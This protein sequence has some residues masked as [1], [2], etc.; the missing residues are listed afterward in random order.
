M[1]HT[2]ILEQP[3]AY[4][5]PLVHMLVALGMVA[6]SGTLMGN[7]LRSELLNAGAHVALL[8]G[9]LCLS[10]FLGVSALL[11]TVAGL[12]SRSWI[13]GQV[14]AN[15]MVW[16]FSATF[17]RASMEKPSLTQDSLLGIFTVACT[18]PTHVF[19]VALPLLIWRYFGRF[20]ISSRPSKSSVRYSIE[21]ILIL[22]AFLAT[23]LSLFR[24]PARLVNILGGSYDILKIGIPQGFSVIAVSFFG[25]IIVAP[26]LMAII[27]VR[28]QRFAFQFIL[29]PFLIITGLAAVFAFRANAPANLKVALI[30]TSAGGFS[31]FVFGL[32][33]LRKVGYAPRFR[34][35][36][37]IPKT[38][39]SPTSMPPNP[40]FVGPRDP[41]RSRQSTANINGVWQPNSTG[42]GL[43][44]PTTHR[45]ATQRDPTETNSPSR[46]NRWAIAGFVGVAAIANAIAFSIERAHYA[47][48]ESMAKQIEQ[49]ANEGVLIGIEQGKDNVRFSNAN[50]THEIVAI[51][52]S[53]ASSVLY[54]DL[55][56][57]LNMDASSL[58]HLA[59]N[60]SICTSEDLPD[61]SSLPD[62]SKIDF[63]G[64]SVD[65][66]V[67]SNIVSTTGIGLYISLAET[68]ISL[69]GIKSLIR[70]A[71][72]KINYLD[73]GGLNLT[74][75]DLAAIDFKSITK[76]GLRDNP[77]SNASLKHLSQME[78]LDLSGTEI[79]GGGLTELTSVN[80]LTI[81]RTR[82]TD[83]DL[84][85]LASP[86][87]VFALSI[88]DTKITAAVTSI[89]TSLVRLRIGDGP[90]QPT[91][92]AQLE[93][94]ML[95]E[96][97]SLNATKFSGSLSG[98]PWTLQHIDLRRSDYPLIAAK[99]IAKNDYS[100]TFN[101]SDH[102]SDEEFPSKNDVDFFISQLDYSGSSRVAEMVSSRLETGR[103]GS[104]LTCRSTDISGRLLTRAIESRLVKFAIPKFPIPGE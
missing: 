35:R 14:I 93:G 59:I 47:P 82:V 30:F 11:I 101:F 7:L 89:L 78:W 92:L 50:P 74:D 5:W 91:D 9:V 87:E 40:A 55:F 98:L 12:F 88:R 73:I 69:S 72:Q 44:S 16:T 42:P 1:R 67:V 97:L 94:L 70:L 96:C 56:D 75:D 81:D 57:G 64:T 2:Q 49:C 85:S 32:A 52:I 80:R 71:H 58:R 100:V 21:N 99:N 39:A 86:R 45:N 3:K 34:A 104:V 83:A 4:Q 15:F 90:I 61:L 38:I 29:A 103:M 17:F 26:T 24:L 95:L 19:A 53:A 33:V 22:M 63:S 84:A 62:R 18:T 68:N 65:D 36:Q 76:V 25:W 37:T 43:V 27:R 77:L 51:Q 66:R 8:L 31:I 48:F 20:H 28:K 41:R 13:V 46:A 60:N 6:I 23:L 10:F 79:G 54:A 102:Q